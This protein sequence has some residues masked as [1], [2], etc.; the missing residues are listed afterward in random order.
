M[1]KQSNLYIF[2]YASAMVVIV[3]TILSVAAIFLKPFQQKNLEIE[4]K[5]DILRSVKLATKANEVNDKNSY[6][7]KEFAKYVV[8]QLVIDSKGEIKSGMS[9]FDIKLKEELA[10]PLGERNL[11]LY[12]CKLDDGSLKYVIPVRGKGLWGPIWGNIAFNEDMNTIYGAVFS[13]KG[14]TPGLGADIDKAFFQDPFVGK[15]ILENQKFVSITVVKG[16]AAPTDI[17][18]VDAISGGTIT[19]KG[20]EDMIKDCLN[21]YVPYFSKNRK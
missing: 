13:H 3:A 5:Q 12:I 15:Q 9:A 19:S 4:K 14:E 11:P 20:V 1:S 17:H 10:K 21:A 8:E 18:G 2:L 7:E 16:G 6:V